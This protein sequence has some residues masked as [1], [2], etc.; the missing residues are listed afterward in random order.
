MNHFQKSNQQ[1]QQQQRHAPQLNCL[2]TAAEWCS[3]LRQL[4]ATRLAPVSVQRRWMLTGPAP[5]SQLACPG[6]NTCFWWQH[7]FVCGWA[8]HTPA[9]VHDCT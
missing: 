2:A 5:H 8:T 1:Q 6:W 9:S 3:P 7:V 4:P